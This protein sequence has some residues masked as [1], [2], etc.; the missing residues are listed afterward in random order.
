MLLEATKMSMKTTSIAL[1]LATTSIA[2][3]NKTPNQSDKQAKETKHCYDHW[4]KFRDNLGDSTGDET[5]VVCP[6]TTFH[7]ATYMED[8]E[9]FTD[10]EIKGRNI[11]IMCGNNGS[12]D[13]KCTFSGGL[14]HLSVTEEAGAD[15]LV[16]GFK[17]TGAQ[18]SSINAWG[19]THSH[20]IFQ[21]CVWENNK[22]AGGAAINIWKNDDDLASAMNVIVNTSS[23]I[24]NEGDDGAIVNQ[25]GTL[26]ID[27]CYFSNNKLGW[28]IEVF[29]EGSIRVSNSCFEDNFGPIY[30]WKGSY[31]LQNNNNYGTGNNGDPDYIC[32]GAYLEGDNGQCSSFPADECS[33]HPLT[34]VA[35]GSGDDGND[36]TIAVTVTLVVVG[37]LVGVGFILRKKFRGGIPMIRL[38][39]K[40]KYYPDDENNGKTDTNDTND[41]NA[42]SLRFNEETGEG[43]DN[44]VVPIYV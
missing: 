16:S 9:K 22:A 44:V 42:G 18:D 7:P 17:F 35:S 38:G 36:T 32:D 37:L 40:R 29:Q 3:A 26:A 21:D 2:S 1:F 10:A 23:F 5:F 34:T 39:G 15:I 19:T 13:N 25:G 24:N 43:D 12:Y 4:T 33:A 11:R 20:I 30:I 28:A 6:G 27:N 8:G 31:L 41:A 14:S